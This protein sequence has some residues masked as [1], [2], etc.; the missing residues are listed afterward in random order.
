MSKMIAAHRLPTPISVTSIFSLYRSR[1][2][3]KTIHQYSY[4]FSEL[5]Y[6]HDTAVPHVIT[7][8][9]R[10][11][12]LNRG[13]LVI[14]P[15]GSNHSGPS[16]EAVIYMIAFDVEFSEMDSLYD[17]VINLDGRQKQQLEQIMALGT[18]ILENV[19]EKG[20]Q[21]GNSLHSRANAFELQRF[22][23]YFEIFLIELYL[24]ETQSISNVHC[25]FQNDEVFDG[26]LSYMKRNID[27]RLTLEDISK[28]TLV[29]A[30]KIRKLFYTKHTC[31]PMQFF[32]L[33]KI[34][35]AID[36][37]CNTTLS[38]SEISSQ[39][40]FSSA[41]YFSKLFKKKTGLSPSEYIKKLKVK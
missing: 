40:G 33:L 17:R 3:G 26:L 27:K 25:R 7:N 4:N 13:Q 24:K 23:N 34:E 20:Y 9:G 28:E 14:L 15:P 5:F 31:A 11:H 29:S 2:H 30:A 21:A 37:M 1:L 6:V 12:I 19:P 41:S 38:Y 22:R 8:N 16:S 36:M 39:L 32:N 10:S 18:H 35:T